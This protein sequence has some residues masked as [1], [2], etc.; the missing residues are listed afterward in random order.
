MDKEIK[1]INTT[2]P[3]ILVSD[4][5]IADMLKKNGY[6]CV[7]ETEAMF[8]FMNNGKLTFSDDIDQHKI[9]YSNKLCI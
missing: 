3:F 7:S 1:S 2:L 8:T 9:V 6:V 4:K 5:S